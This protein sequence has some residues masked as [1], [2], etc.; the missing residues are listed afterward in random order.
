MLRGS[1]VLWDLRLA[2]P[3]DLYGYTQFTV[4]VGCHGDSFDRYL[5][6]VEE[7]RNSLLLIDQCLTL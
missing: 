7:M 1:G 3:Y 6:R 4:P 2:Q 5:L